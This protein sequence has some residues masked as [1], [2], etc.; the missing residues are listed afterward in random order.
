MQDFEE[1]ILNNWAS[2]FQ[3]PVSTLKQSGTTLLPDEKY[4]Q[5]KMIIL[6]HIDQHTFAVYDPS[7]T[8]LLNDILARLPVNIALS[9]DHL[10]QML[11]ASS[12]ASHD[13]GLLHYLPPSDPPH[14]PTPRSFAVR[15][16][17]PSD[18]EPLA[19]LHSNCTPEE[20]DE[21]YVVIDCATMYGCFH[22]RV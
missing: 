17:G 15:E 9:G 7:Y 3:C 1:I 20:V 21:A 2:R 18:Q 6:W 10:Q 13:I 5:Q 8:E 14:V 4:A 19:V 12:I 11:V 22:H 16:L